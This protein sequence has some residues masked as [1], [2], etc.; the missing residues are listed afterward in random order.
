MALVRYPA[1]EQRSGR[2]GGLVHSHNRGGPYNR[3]ASIPTNPN[4]TRQSNVRANLSNLSNNWYVGL[5]QAQ[6]DAWD[7]YAANNP[8][9]NRLGMSIF[10]T[11]QNYYIR[12]NSP[13]LNAGLDTL[14]DAPTT[15]LDAEVPAFLTATASAATQIV[16][17]SWLGFAYWAD[18]DDA[19][20]LVSVGR[21]QNAS[22]KF[23]SSPYRYNDKI[24]GDS[25]TAPVAPYALSACPW[26][27]AEGQRLWI[28]ARITEADGRLGDWATYNFLCAA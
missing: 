24:E 14:D 12:C 5:T 7:Q 17:V 6:R 18:T 2:T 21:P 28:K 3:S 8:V 4:T 27:F 20:M 22:R 9:T 13:R 11:G 19:A 16:S 26:V 25:T 23:F 10:L 15:V 1:G